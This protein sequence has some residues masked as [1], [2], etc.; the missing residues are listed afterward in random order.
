MHAIGLPW[1]NYCISP[2]FNKF[3]LIPTLLRITSIAD[4]GCRNHFRQTNLQKVIRSLA[5]IYSFYE[6]HSREIP[7]EGSPKGSANHNHHG[8]YLIWL[9]YLLDQRLLQNNRYY[10]I[11]TWAIARRIGLSTYDVKNGA[12]GSSIICPFYLPKITGTTELL[13]GPLRDALVY[14]LMMWKMVLLDHL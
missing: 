6:K 12:I 3:S 11:T 5:S 10:R 1:G 8:T 9:Q 4:F 7:V 2:P 14:P 13:R